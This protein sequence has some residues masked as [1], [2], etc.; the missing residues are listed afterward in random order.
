MSK[1]KYARAQTALVEI[2]K[3]SS[4]D[5]KQ[6]ALYLLAGLKTSASEAEI[7]YQEV[8]QMNPS[9]RWATAAQVEL[10]KIQYALGDYR[11][12]IEILEKSSACRKSDEACY[13]EGLSAVMLKRYDAAK[14]SLSQV[15]SDRYR[16]AAGLALADA[17]MSLDNRE[18]A[19]RK[20]RSMARSIAG[21]TALYRY[22]ECLEEQGDIV[23]AIGIFE[24]V[25]RTFDQT[26]EALLAAEKLEALRS[27]P[28]SRPA[29]TPDSQ[30]S[31]EEDE[32][33]PPLTTGFTLQFG[34]FQDRANAIKLAAEL[35]NDLP[36]VRIDSD[37]LNFKEVH[38][39]R[40]GYF[41]S[42]A[43]AER[44]A[45]EVARHTRE[46]CSIMPLP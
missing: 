14:Q 24:E 37:L 15:K 38:R 6:E 25:V 3:S 36:G 41:K 44:K 12:A 32:R 39:V 13:F 1:M 31:T 46:S 43:E 8:A 28:P 5:E 20:Y 27:A 26:P 4:G 35:K 7:I 34:S 18:E 2:A 9:G 17:E 19:C 40:Y 10:A 30:A 45:E 33:T 22:G 11:A 23:A 16:S 21:P 42:R 29:R